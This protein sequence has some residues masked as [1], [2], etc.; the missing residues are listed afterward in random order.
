MFEE[1]VPRPV[2]SFLAVVVES[3]AV[4]VAVER[5]RLEPGDQ[6]EPFVVRKVVERGDDVVERWAI[7]L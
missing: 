4:E 6:L 7:D 2:V 1:D 3:P 5:S